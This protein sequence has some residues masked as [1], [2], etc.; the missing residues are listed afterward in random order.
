MPDLTSLI[1]VAKFLGLDPRSLK[2][3]LTLKTLF[4]QG[5][6]VVSGHIINDSITDMEHSDML[7]VLFFMYCTYRQY[8]MYVRFFMYCMNCQYYMYIKTCLKVCGR[9]C[10][11]SNSAHT[12]TINSSMKHLPQH[13]LQHDQERK[14][15]YTHFIYATVLI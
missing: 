5:E 14:R 2:E 10:C 3:A 7:Y 1:R 4:A 8:H 11:I 13:H 6:T 15:I 12:R 9:P